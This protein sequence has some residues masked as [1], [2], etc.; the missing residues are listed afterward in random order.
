MKKKSRKFLKLLSMGIL[1]FLL[2]F[3]AHF[4][5]R[6]K[7]ITKMSQYYFVDIYYMCPENDGGACEAEISKELEREKK[8]MARQDI[9]CPFLFVC[10]RRAQ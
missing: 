4:I 7:V 5:Y 3:G 6:E 8:N 2:I 10:Y 9:D 1:I